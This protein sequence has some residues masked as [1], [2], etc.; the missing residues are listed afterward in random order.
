MKVYDLIK[1]LDTRVAEIN[2][3]VLRTYD[4]DF[5]ENILLFALSARWKDNI[6]NDRDFSE[7]RN[8]LVKSWYTINDHD[9]I[10]L[11]IIV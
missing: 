1:T 10:K 4:Y 11:V 7:H 9:K 3:I 2:S 6:L 8:M 5:G